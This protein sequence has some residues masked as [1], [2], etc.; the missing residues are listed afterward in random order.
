MLEP[1]AGADHHHQP[2]P[3]ERCRDDPDTLP[4]RKPLY[5]GQS[6]L[7]LSAIY[8][9]ESKVAALAER[10]VDGLVDEIVI[11]NDG[12]TDRSADILREHGITVIDQ[13]HLGLGAAIKRGIRYARDHGFTIAVLLAG[14]GK[15]D[16]REIPKLLA[17]ILND[18]ADY[19][20]GSR[21][22]PGGSAPNTPVFRLIAIKFLSL[23]FSLYCRKRCTDLTNGFRAY[24][25]SLFDDPRINIWQDWLDNYECEYYLHFKVHT[26]G[27]K[28]TEVPV[29]KTYPMQKGVKYSKIKPITGWWHMLRPFILLGLHIKK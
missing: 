1:T 8:N 17:P 4:R 14:N 12:S 6:V 24:R 11:V 22:L 21:F 23:L 16:P 18:G 2:A 29:S 3:G 13:P 19:V 25:L 28:V 9:E 27:Y 15:D 26:L 20:Q 5:P 10:F 7:A